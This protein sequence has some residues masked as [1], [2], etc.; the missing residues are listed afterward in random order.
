MSTDKEWEEFISIK[1]ISDTSSYEEG[2]HILDDGGSL[3]LNSDGS[4]TYY[5]AD[6]GTCYLNAD[7]SGTYYG[8][9]GSTFYLNSDGSG[10]YYGSTG[11]TGYLNPDGSGSYYGSAGSTGYLNS[12][13]SGTY[14]GEDGSSD[15]IES[16]LD[17]IGSGGNHGTISPVAE[18]IASMIG[19]KLA[20]SI[21][22]ISYEITQE[23][24]QEISYSY[25]F[26]GPRI[27]AARLEERQ[28][29]R[30]FN[31]HLFT[32][33]LTFVF[34]IYGVDRFCRG[35]VKLGI[36]K[37]FTLGGLGIW[38]LVDFGVAL[39]KSYAAG[40]RNVDNLTFDDEGRYIH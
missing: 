17:H 19:R 9:D 34:G 3:S 27:E 36:L 7:G 15:Y 18:A 16:S 33:L 22:D 12:D 38:Y 37:I 1:N 23:P 32:W 24:E 26:E 21:D 28:A 39:V 30:V 35:Q 25:S 40:Y 4:G 20:G 5:G 2:Y 13:G 11:S 6:G 8:S 10:T 31:K 14:Y 29:A